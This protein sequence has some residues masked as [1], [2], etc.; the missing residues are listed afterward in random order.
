MV[1]KLHK[2]MVMYIYSTQEIKAVN[3]MVKNHV[4]NILSNRHVQCYLHIRYR[5]NLIFK[6]KDE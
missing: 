6:Y 1:E 5:L 2:K 3:K 4:V